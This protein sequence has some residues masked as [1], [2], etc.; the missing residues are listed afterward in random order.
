MSMWTYNFMTSV[1]ELSLA[2]FKKVEVEKFINES[3]HKFNALR[4][5][6]KW[7]LGIYKI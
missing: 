1:S 6:I 4:F 3:T 7:Y 5:F 2:L